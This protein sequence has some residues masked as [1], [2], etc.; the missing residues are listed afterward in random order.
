[1]S[2]RLPQ[3][4]GIDVGGTKIAAARISP[5][6]EIL[7]REVVPSPADDTDAIIDSMVAAARELRT[8][9]VVVVGISAAGMVETGTGVVRFAPNLAWRE[10]DLRER[11]G[12]PLRLPAVVENDNNAA[13]WGEY[14]F[15]AGRGRRHVLFVG[16]GTGIGG[17]II[18]DGALV[19]GAHGFAAEI[20]HIVVQPDGERCGCGNR[21][22][23]ETVA[24]GTAISRASRRAVT[25]HPH[26]R[27]A[28][29]AQGDPGRGTGSLVTRA[30]R[31]GDPAACGILV[32][33]GHRLGEGIAG[34][35][36]VL[37]PE[38]VIVGGG[39]AEAGDLLLDPARAAFRRTV[40]GPDHRPAV[41]IVVAE[42]GTDAGVIGA[43]TLALEASDQRS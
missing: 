39:A 2:D 20:G 29:L 28:E 9:E 24:S 32:E 10:A 40:E 41:P 7:A 6:G 17:G 43:A 4:I 35:V 25:R 12:G 21:G 38:V 37:D 34:L 3:A 14:R 30:A 42:L 33:V 22:C 15:G 27:I 23:W 26:S 1:V 31:E 36:N 11:V 13:A 19:R 18:V 16:I 5:H 8:D